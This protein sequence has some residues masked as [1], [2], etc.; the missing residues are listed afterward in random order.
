MVSGITMMTRY[1]LAFAT[2]ARPIP[3][4][5][6]VGSIIVAP[7][8]KIPLYENEK[9]TDYQIIFETNETVK[10]ASNWKPADDNPF[11]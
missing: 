10:N 9:Y 5:P 4:F 1:P 2:E 7:G 3:V 6:L 8:F 11:S